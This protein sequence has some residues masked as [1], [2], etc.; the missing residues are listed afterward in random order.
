MGAGNLVLSDV[1]LPRSIQDSFDGE[2]EIT[3]PD[4]LV[5]RLRVAGPKGPDLFEGNDTA[6]QT[7]WTSIT[8]TRTGS[9]DT[10]LL[11]K[12]PF[13]SSKQSLT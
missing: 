12:G 1:S 3:V 9:P 7:Q 6:R 8:T 2:R 13:I 5:C 10:D 4:L 11:W